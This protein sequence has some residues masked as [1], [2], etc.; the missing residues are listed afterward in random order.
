M[1]LTC[2]CD[3]DIWP[4]TTCYMRPDDYA[5]LT[6]RRAIRCKSCGALVKPGATVIEW[7]RFKIP[8]DD[9]EVKIWGEDGEIPR[10]SQFHCERCADIYF[11]LRELGFEC[12]RPSENMPDLARQYARTYGSAKR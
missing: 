7:E 8:G 11:S 3:D 1:P 6:G 12:I 9:I 5:T 10:A 4:G 2:F